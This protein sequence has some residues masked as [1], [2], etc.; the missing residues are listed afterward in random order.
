MENK[1]EHCNILIKRRKE[2]EERLP[3]VQNLNPAGNIIPG[4]ITPEEMAELGNIEKDLKEDCLEFLS[5]E[6]RLEIEK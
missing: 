5:P 3:Y 1:K 6:D 4:K 2:L